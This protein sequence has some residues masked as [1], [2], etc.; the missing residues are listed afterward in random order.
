MVL[1]PQDDVITAEAAIILLLFSATAASLLLVNK[2]VMFYIPLPSFVS[3]LQFVVTAIFSYGWML[4]GNAPVETWE[5][6]KVKAYLYYTG[7][8]VGSIYT[9]M[10]ALQHANVETII[11]FR[12]CCPLVV[13]IITGRSQLCAARFP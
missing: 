4:S 7:M 10:K 8:F 6:K 5:W 11:V 12:S 3:T 9:N 2:L 1:K 13:A